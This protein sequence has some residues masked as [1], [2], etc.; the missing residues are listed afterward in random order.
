MQ[1]ISLY[2]LS[3]S[4]LFNFYKTKFRKQK[5][6]I[7]KKDNHNFATLDF[8]LKTKNIPKTVLKF[9]TKKSIIFLVKIIK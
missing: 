7:M 8:K 1:L 5:N 4:V 6:N 2:K 9:L 3:V